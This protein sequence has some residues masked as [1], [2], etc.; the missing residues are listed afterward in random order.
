MEENTN[1]WN[2]KAS[3]LTVAESMKLSAAVPIIMIGCTA[4]AV[5][6]VVVADKITTKFRTVRMNRNLRKIEIVED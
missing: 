4:A 2:T 1:L 3:D 6:V 5:T